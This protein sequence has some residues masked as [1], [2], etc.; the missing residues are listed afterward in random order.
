MVEGT[1]PGLS[2]FRSKAPPSRLAQESLSFYGGCVLDRDLRYAMSQKLQ[3][4]K[5]QKPPSEPS[6][7][8]SVL[9]KQ[10]RD[11]IEDVWGERLPY[12][13]DWPSRVDKLLVEAPDRWVQSCCVLCSN[14][15]ALD[16]GV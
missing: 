1:V 11:S 6:A 13:G 7:S 5:K 14:G 12:V 8:P 15:C 3:S 4:R 9:P 10:T 16:I 2:P